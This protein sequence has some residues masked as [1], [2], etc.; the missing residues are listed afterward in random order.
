MKT[1]PTLLTARPASFERIPGTCFWPAWIVLLAVALFLPAAGWAQDAWRFDPSFE[2][3]PLRL[4]SE[5]AVGVHV[6]GSGKVL[7]DTF[8]QELLSG[9]N[10]QRIGALVRLDPETGAI[11]PSWQPDPTVTGAGFLGVAEAP[12][13]KI[14]Y[15]T[16]LTGELATKPSDPAVFR[17]IRLNT[18]GTRDLSFNSPIFG[19]IT[20]FLAV[21]PD[22]KIIVCSGGVGLVGTPPPGSIV[23]TVRLNTD[24]SLDS[25]FHS[26][27]FQYGPNDPPASVETGNYFDQGVFGNPVI[28]PASGKIYFC[29]SFLYV[30]GQPRPSIVRCN[31]D[32]T[33]DRSF[34]PRGLNEQFFLFGRAMVLQAGGKVVLGGTHLET[35]AGGATHYAL[36]RF[37]ADGTLD[38]SFILTPTTDSSGVP[39]VPGYT[40]P[41]DIHVLPDGKILTGDTRVLRFLPDGSVDPS[42]TPL[43]YTSP[44]YSPDLG[45]VA[46]FRFAVNPDTGEAY[47]ENPGPTYARLGGLPVGNIT[48]LTAAGTI[49]STFQ[50]PVFESEDFG[51]D[52]QIDG[53]GALFVSGFHTDFGSTPNAPIARLNADGTRDATYSLGLRPFPDKQA[54]EFALF[55]NNAAYVV[56]HSGSFS[57]GYEFSNLVRLSPKGAI[58]RRFLLSPDLQQ[59][60]SINSYAGSDTSKLSLPQISAVR[61]GEVYLFGGTPQLTVNADGNV[62]P[63]CIKAD[64]TEDMRVPPLGFPTG[65]VIRDVSGMIDMGATGYLHRLAQTPDGGFIILAST[66]PFP[67]PG[68]LAF[69]NY[70]VI[71]LRADGRL[72][73]RFISPTLTSTS[74]TILTFPLLVDPVTGLSYQPLNGFY[75]EGDNPVSSATVLPD[76]SVL[77]SGTFHLDDGAETY[78][79]VKLSANGRLDSSFHLPVVENIGNSTRPVVITHLRSAPDGK[80]WILGRFD[81]IGGI[82]APGVARLNPDGSLDSS[83]SLADVAYYDSFGDHADVVFAG[84]KAAYLVGTFRR[85]GE[86][87][88]F[89]VTRI[90]ASDPTDLTKRH[91]PTSKGA[92]RPQNGGQRQ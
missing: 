73:R 66:A 4:T 5:S 39:F 35:I 18:D 19:V 88:P 37:N 40:G 25:T 11:D 3:T 27:N 6:L 64:G 22:G 15:A 32:G 70:R 52:V 42:F 57:G 29:G 41:R 86:P 20:R 53:G 28:D 31:A 36:L 63:E 75:E 33:A 10:G 8:N 56:Y 87:F 2:R 83:F 17:L 60:V 81:T 34:V 79:V 61:N 59:A 30:N 54:A 48:K 92:N 90:V 69:Y 50:S 45:T 67:A 91:G 23:E 26:P 82:P 46:A 43:D 7:V 14:Y 12:D 62:K 77:L 65:E 1:S 89:A 16:A 9:A 85:P 76:G 21:Q 71:R 58:D 13:G 49:D 55:P 24:G 68:P 47:L 84:D 72:D 80:V 44:F 51:P 38:P 74:P 78:S